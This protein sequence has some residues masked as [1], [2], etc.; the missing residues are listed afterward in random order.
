MVMMY[1]WVSY[2]DD[3]FRHALDSLQFHRIVFESRKMTLL[4]KLEDTGRMSLVMDV[5]IPVIGGVCEAKLRIADHPGRACVHNIWLCL[6]V[7]YAILA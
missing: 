3:G 4:I 2:E 6:W 7:S 1:F 5:G